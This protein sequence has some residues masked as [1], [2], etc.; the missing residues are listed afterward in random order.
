MIVVVFPFFTLRMLLLLPE[1]VK[2]KNVFLGKDM[3][4][5][6]S[7]IP[8]PSAY[9]TPERIFCPRD[10][11]PMGSL[12][13]SPSKPLC[14]LWAD[15]EAWCSC[16]TGHPWS[17]GLPIRKGASKSK[18]CV[19]RCDASAVRDWVFL[20]RANKGGGEA[21]RSVYLFGLRDAFLCP[22]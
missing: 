16:T 5:Q 20:M 12:L 17:D 8:I 13:S 3:A 19:S 11:L 22:M 15:T 9:C 18:E 4:H 10:Y 2:Y 14:W 21:Q 6:N 1:I 7:Q